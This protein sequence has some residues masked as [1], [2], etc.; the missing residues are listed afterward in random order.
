[1]SVYE[2]SVTFSSDVNWTSTDSLTQGAGWSS[3]NV[4]PRMI[5]DVNGDGYGDVVGFGSTY[6]FVLLSSGSSFL[7]EEKW[8]TEFA[9]NAGWTTQDAYPRMMGDVNGD[10]F[11]D[12]IGFYTDNVWVSLSNGSTFQ[13]STS[14]FSGDFAYNDGWTSNLVYPR[15]VGDVNGDG[16]DDLVCFGENTVHLAIANGTHFELQNASLI[17]GDFTNSQ[18][19]GST[20]LRTLGD[21]NGDGMADFGAFGTND[22]YAGIS[23][24]VAPSPT[25]APTATFLPTVYTAE[26]FQLNSGSCTLDATS[27]C[28]YS[29]NYPSNYGDGD[30]CS[31]TV[32]HGATLSVD[33][34]LLETTYDYLTVD[35][36]TY[37]SSTGPDGVTVTSG[38]TITFTTDLSINYAGF[39]I[40]GTATQS[41]PSQLP[42]AAPSGLPSSAPTISPSTPPSPMPT[43]AP[44]AQPTRAPTFLPT[45]RPTTFYRSNVRLFVV[46]VVVYIVFKFQ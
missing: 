31:I 26:I 15:L 13:T 3:Q 27:T 42:S 38:I 14:W 45:P 33:Y 34:F 22:V 29:P 44:T 9:K 5:A 30:S 2:S 28:F 25:P 24:V 8:S 4:Y 7:P 23:S 10:G 39:A 19:W 17:S 41:S 16:K 40:C 37:T 6:V 20:T 32:L 36:T 12:I 21:I 18:G 35:G 46:V 1:V 11:A 43:Y